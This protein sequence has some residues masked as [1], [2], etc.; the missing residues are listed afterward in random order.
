[1][2]EDGALNDE[3][4][5]RE[6]AK[7]KVALNAATLLAYF[8]GRIGGLTDAIKDMEAETKGLREAAHAAHR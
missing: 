4:A 8:V 3:R 7:Y 2:P 1:M 5:R 6:L